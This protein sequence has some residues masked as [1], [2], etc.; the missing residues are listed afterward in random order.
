MKKLFFLMNPYAGTQR[1]NRVLT[2]IIRLFNSRGYAVMIHMTAGPGDGAKVVAEQGKDA[3]LIVCAGGDGTFNETITGLLRS[4]LETPVGYIPCGSTNDFANS[5]HLPTNPIQAAQA[6]VDGTPEPY[7]VGRFGQRYFSYVASF[8]AFTRASYATP[9]NLKNLLGHLA[10]VL[11][12]VK[13]LFQIPKL[14]VAFDTDAGSFAGDYIFGA[15]SNSTSV[16]GILSLDPNVVD[17]QDGKF[18]LMLV[19][20]PK[21]A[22]ELISLVSALTSQRY[23]SPMLTFKTVRRLIVR[24]ETQID[25]TLDGEHAAGQ[26]TIDIENLHHAITLVRGGK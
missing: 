10:Y 17:M 25:W 5:L 6:I 4:G 18:E 1:A 24:T 14:Q 20:P 23:V 21:D 19:R 13:E 3:E 16:G 7:D 11:N 15:V 9:Q 26:P 8:G 22:G 2:D 12:G